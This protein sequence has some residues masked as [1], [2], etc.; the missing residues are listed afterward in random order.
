MR[1]RE[2]ISLLSGAVITWPRA[3]TPKGAAE[4]PLVAVLLA[5]SSTSAA[6]YV[7]AFPQGLRELGYVEGQNI[8]I[9]YR[10]AEGDPKVSGS[11]AFAV[12]GF[13]SRAALLHAT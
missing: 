7:S 2:F 8:E 10:Y 4:H 12:T 5:V 6:R 9:L 1:R 13:A 3:A 11:A